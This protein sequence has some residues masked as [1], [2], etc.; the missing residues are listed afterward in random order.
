M[1]CAFPQGHTFISYLYIRPRDNGN[2]KHQSI[3]Y[4]LLFYSGSY[5]YVHHCN[6]LMLSSRA[7]SDM[8]NI[9][10]VCVLIPSPGV[11]P[12]AVECFVLLDAD[13]YIFC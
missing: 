7:S 5:I 12:C 13:C 1:V 3:Y 6:T 9:C 2:G 10:N 8:T 11:K 4:S